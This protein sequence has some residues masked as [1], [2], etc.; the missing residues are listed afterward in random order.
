MSWFLATIY[1][2][3][4]HQAEEA[5][6]GAWRR[7]LLADVDGDVLEIG[8]GTG[9]NLACYGPDVRRL[10]L[11][12]P[13]PRMRAQLQARVDATARTLRAEVVDTPGEGLGQPDQ[14]FDVVV[15]TLVLCSVTDPRAALAEVRRVLRPG[16]RFVFLEHVASDDA[17]RRRWQQRIEPVW[18]RL[19]D[20]CH[21][22]RPTEQLI[23]DAGFNLEWTRRE[24]M[25]KA[26]PVI[27][28]TVRG[29]ARRPG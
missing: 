8:A 4:M 5:G 26:M 10:V 15:G 21:L 2:R 29:V 22:T 6:L 25:R 19:A 23:V 13:E 18:K 14:A 11:A 7:E 12:E 27:R 3:F 28:P 17:T 9:A 24:S 16:G 1:D 20:N